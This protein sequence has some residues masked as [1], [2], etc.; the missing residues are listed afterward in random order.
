MVFRLSLVLAI[1][2]GHAFAQC[3]YGCTQYLKDTSAFYYLNTVSRESNNPY[4]VP[5]FEAVINGEKHTGKLQFNICDKVVKPAQCAGT[6][7][8]STGYFLVGEDKCF[9]LSAAKMT[10]WKI[11]SLEGNKLPD[12]IKITTDNSS[13]KKLELE[14]EYK[15]ICDK[16]ARTPAIEAMQKGDIVHIQLKSETACGRDLLGPF[17]DLLSNPYIIYPAM[18]IIGLILAPFGIKVYRSILVF[19]GFI[20]GYFILT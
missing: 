12:G 17:P 5:E 1:L 18:I 4:T 6:E 20:A 19:L 14:V 2:A 11:S 7:E 8:E 16:D 9:Q 10:K 15:L 3:G 13:Y